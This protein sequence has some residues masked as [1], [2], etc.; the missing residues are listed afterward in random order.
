MSML[1]NKATS[2]SKTKKPKAAYARY[3]P[4]SNSNSCLK[5]AVFGQKSVK[6]VLKLAVFC[7]IYCSQYFMIWWCRIWDKTLMLAL[8]QFYSFDKMWVFPFYGVF[9]IQT[10]I[11]IAETVATIIITAYLTN[12]KNTSAC[13]SACASCNICC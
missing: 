13:A 2:W 5:L 7:T 10:I 8:I 4:G 12:S 9:R 6:K 3:P 1:F 11:R